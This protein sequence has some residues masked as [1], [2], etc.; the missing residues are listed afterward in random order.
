[1]HE[2]LLRKIQKDKYE[3]T[4]RKSGNRGKETTCQVCQPMHPILSTDYARHKRRKK[5]NA[6]NG[7]PISKKDPPKPGNQGGE[8]R[9]KRNAGRRMA[10][11]NK[12][13]LAGLQCIPDTDQFDSKNYVSADKCWDE[14]DDK[15]TNF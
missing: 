8:A 1:M 14:D 7:R 9:I 2:K 3:N 13:I 5:A 11:A 4:K 10:A 12:M 15:I 6:K